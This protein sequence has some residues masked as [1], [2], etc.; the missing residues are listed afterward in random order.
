MSEQIEQ[1]LAANHATRDQ[2]AS[3]HRA[4]ATL[5]ERDLAAISKESVAVIE[6]KLNGQKVDLKQL[7]TVARLAKKLNE[8]QFLAFAAG[9]SE[10]LPMLVLSPSEMELLRAGGTWWQNALAIGSAVVSV[11]STVATD[12]VAAMGCAGAI[13]GSFQKAGWA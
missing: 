8:D 11:A 9:D 4:Y 7:R 3:V 6:R 1:F 2:I 5:E 13:A 12:G 10:G